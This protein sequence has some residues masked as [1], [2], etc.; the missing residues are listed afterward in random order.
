MK[1]NFLSV[2]PRFF[3]ITGTFISGGSEDGLAGATLA[4]F[5]PHRAQELMGTVRANG[6][7]STCA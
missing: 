7:R 5:T 4:A 3:T 1:V 6:T 2:E